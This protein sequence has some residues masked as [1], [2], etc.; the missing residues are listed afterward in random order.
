M[1]WYPDYANA[2]SW[3]T[4]LFHSSPKPYFNLAYLDDKSLDGQIDALP[5]EAAKGGAAAD[6]AY[7][8]AQKSV[9]AQDALLPFFVATYQRPYRAS[10]QDYVDNPAYANVVFAYDVKPGAG[11]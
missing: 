11:S 6:S 1:Y 2:D 8:T 10:L 7:R 5:Q 9:M 3:F 4:N